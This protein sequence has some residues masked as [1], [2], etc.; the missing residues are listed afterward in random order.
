MAFVKLDCAI[1]HSSIWPDKEAR[2]IFI[3]ALLMASPYELKEPAPQISAISLDETGWVIPAGWYGFV[4]AAGVGII[5]TAGVVRDA[6]LAAMVRLSSP[7]HE[8]RSPAH[9]GRRMAR[10]SGGYLILNY[11][12][13]RDRDH[14][15]A[16]RMRRLRERDKIAKSVRRNGDETIDKTVTEL[17]N[18]T[19]AEDRGQRTDA[20]SSPGEEEW[21]VIEKSFAAWA[22]NEDGPNGKP[23]D[24]AKLTPLLAKLN[25]EQQNEISSAIDFCRKAG[26]QFKTEAYAAGMIVSVIQEGQ[27]KKTK[28]RNGRGAL[29]VPR[30]ISKPGSP[31]I[32]VKP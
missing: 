1:L 28:K 27:H 31:I 21:S 3:T 19:Q 29:W 16:D 13:Y 8:S 24:R 18:V 7:E 2:D 22:S 12:A 6:G 5:H 15:A 32:E 10:I 23:I 14:T 11:F 17:R 20:Y 26:K 4:P 9:E 30:D 25:R